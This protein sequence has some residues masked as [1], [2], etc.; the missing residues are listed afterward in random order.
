MAQYSFQTKLTSPDETLIAGLF[1]DKV[2]VR[3]INPSVVTPKFKI[4]FEDDSYLDCAE[5]GEI[6]LK[7]KKFWYNWYNKDGSLIMKFHNHDHKDDD[8][9]R[10]DTKR[11]DPL[12][13]QFPANVTD[14][15]GNIRDHGY[16]ECLEDVLA[17]IWTIMKAI[18][19]K[20]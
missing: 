14:T 7:L 12:H 11:F 18:P 16:F 2:T 3:I 9:A 8:N 5:E 20:K 10:E 6:N 19:H 15:N 13:V 1:P 4:T 17:V